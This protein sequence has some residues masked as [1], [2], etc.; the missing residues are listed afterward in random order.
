MKR[1]D[2]LLELTDVNAAYGQIHVLFD[3][4]LSVPEGSIVALV[5][6]NGAGKTTTLKTAMGEL[7]PLSGEVTFDGDQLN[8]LEPHEISQRGLA[9]VPETRRIFPHLTVAENLR[10][11]HLGHDVDDPDFETIFEYFPRLEERLTQ[12][13]GQMSGGEQQMLTIARALISDPDLLLVDEP[14]EG[15]MPTL[16]EDLSEILAQINRDGTTILLVE[17]NI[18][19]A[20]SLSDCVYV[21]DEGRIQ[22]A[23]DS[24]VL[25]EDEELKEQYLAV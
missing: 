3:V 13:A 12:K 22:F 19:M 20:L 16:V 15:L 8:G 11:G 6:R 23:D 2:P 24:E 10:V 18:D 14:T 7:E 25:Q 17:Q 4:S 9:F 21:I 1:D 5:G